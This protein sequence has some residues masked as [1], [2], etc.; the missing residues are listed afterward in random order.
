MSVASCTEIF[1][2]S[3]SYTNINWFI[4]NVLLSL[5]YYDN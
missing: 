1:N 4:E 5:E 2:G 3:K